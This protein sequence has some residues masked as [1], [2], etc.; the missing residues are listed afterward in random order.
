MAAE[1]HVDRSIDH[2]DEFVRTNVLGTI[3]ILNQSVKYGVERY[4]QIS[5]DEVY[6]SLGSKGYFTEKTPMSPNSPYS[7][8]KASADNFVRAYGK[9]YGLDFIITRCSNNYGPYQ[10]PEKL[11]PLVINNAINDISIPVYGDGKNVRDWIYV[12][13][14][15]HGILK[16]LEKGRSGDVYNFGGN[17]ELTNI[18]LIQKILRQLG[19]TEDLIKFIDDRPGHDFRYAIEYSKAS[20]EL[21]WNPKLVFDEGLKSTINWY[22]DNKLWM[23]KITTGDYR[24]YYKLRYT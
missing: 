17:S 5:T 11:I 10:F 1:S 3:N 4:V 16:S 12:E 23:N 14:H 15:C 2:P 24:E 22:V 18:V 8:S 19:K 21:D 13:D 6:G 7:A 9:T 20:R